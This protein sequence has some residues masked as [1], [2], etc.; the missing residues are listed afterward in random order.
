MLFNLQSVFFF[1]YYDIPNKRRISVLL[2]YFKKYF[3]YPI[4]FFI[5][6]YPLNMKTFLN[7][8][9]D[10]CVYN[11]QFVLPLAHLRKRLQL[12]PIRMTMLKVVCYYGTGW[13]AG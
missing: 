3:A 12:L 6:F 5:N 2:I 10:F 1:E 9:I 7:L 11:H 13:Q 4:R 8:I